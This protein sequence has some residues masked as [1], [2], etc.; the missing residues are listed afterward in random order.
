MLLDINPRV[1]I[2]KPDLFTNPYPAP[3]VPTNWPKAEGPIN[4]Y[5]PPK[6]RPVTPDEV[7]A[8]LSELELTFP[9]G[10]A[11]EQ[12]SSIPLTSMVEQTDTPLRVTL[13][14]PIEKEGTLRLS[15]T[16]SSPF[17]DFTTGVEPNDDMISLDLRFEMEEEE[18]FKSALFLMVWF[19]LILPYRVEHERFG[20]ACSV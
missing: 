16:E 17:C 6:A 11:S 7:H 8:F 18:I 2:G 3:T 19:L 9:H 20:T 10:V 12:P 13:D 5:L 4:L 15:L 1:G 14:A